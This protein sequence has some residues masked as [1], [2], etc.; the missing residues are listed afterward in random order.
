MN[1]VYS[2]AYPSLPDLQS[3]ADDTPAPAIA[4]GDP[5]NDDHFVAAKLQHTKRKHLHETGLATTVAEV[6]AS[7][8]RK[9]QVLVEISNQQPVGPDAIANNL[10]NLIGTVRNLVN[11]VTTDNAAINARI[12]N[13]VN[14]VTTDNA[15]INAR[16]TDL[17]DTVNTN[18]AAINA[19][20]TNLVHTV[21]TNHADLMTT[22]NR[23]NVRIDIE[24]ARNV[25]RSTVRTGDHEIT[26]VS[27]TNGDFPLDAVSGFH[28]TSLT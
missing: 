14:T 22:V 16:I 4:P 25:N 24:S 21:N 17:V 1:A 27:D 7:K 15:A 19:R 11:T 10:N 9:T 13:L 8:K 28:R 5:L 2:S 18:H 3:Q 12:T 20:I 26:A 6:I 23:T